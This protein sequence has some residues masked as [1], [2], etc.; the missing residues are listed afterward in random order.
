MSIHFP[1][2]I[3]PEVSPSVRQLAE[4]AFSRAAGAPLIPG[5]GIALLRDAA[6]NYPAWLEAMRSAT[7]HIH[8]E[9]YF[10]TEDDVGRQFADLMIAKAAEGVKVRLIYDWFG[11]FGKASR[12]FWRELEEAGVDVRCFNPPR[13]DQPLGLFIRDHRKMLAVDGSLGFVTGLCVGRMWAGF[14]ER[15]IEPWRDTGVMVTG[16]AVADIE[17]AFAEVWATLGTP[18]PEDEIPPRSSLH[19]AGDVTMQV[20]ATAPYTAGLYRLDQLIAAVARTSLWL[21]DAYFVGLPTYVQALR[22]AALDGVDVRLLVPGTTDIPVIRAVSRAGYQPLLEAGVRVFEWNG[23]ML[24]AKTAVADGRWARIGSTN[25]NLSSWIGNYELDVAV[26]DEAF[27]RGMERVYLEDLSR[28]TEVVLSERKRVCLAQT[29]PRPPYRVR[30][31]AKG[32]I[33]RA[34]MGMIKLGNVVEAAISSQRTLGPAEAK[35]TFSA[36]AILLALA[37]VAVLWPELLAVPFAFFSIWLAL[38]LLLRANK[39]R[40]RRNA[41]ESDHSV[42]SERKQPPHCQPHADDER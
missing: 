18:L 36:G 20:I 9:N 2:R 3:F 10:I 35:I 33:S 19:P 40:R 24:H 28:S 16:P 29:R 30:R 8:F 1:R 25:L 27:A 37:V 17:Q 5:N 14:P 21:T 31:K 39:L 6:Q 7:E 15:A 38:S 26:E 42:P 13:I 4:Q 32:S 23:P 22:A 12:R 11:S 34:G 41:S